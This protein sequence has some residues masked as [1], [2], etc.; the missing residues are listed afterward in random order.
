[1]HSDTPGTAKD[2]PVPPVPIRD[3]DAVGTEIASSEAPVANKSMWL[4][5]KQAATDAST[6]AASVGAV[7]ASKAATIATP[8]A[9][10]AAEIGKQAYGAAGEATKTAV[11]SGKQAYA[12][13][14][15]ESAI[16]Y[17]DGEL[18]QRGAKQVIKET[19]GA[20]IGKFDQVTGKRLVEL[21]ED[22]L[23]IQDAYNDILASR[24]AEALERIAKLEATIERRREH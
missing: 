24:L 23:R 10:K 22:K 2:N 16:D 13:S 7:V 1:M 14:M 20:V 11:E 6:H 8:V 18:D 9:A 17:I 3:E 12:G 19:A 15:L 4:K 21:L 5:A